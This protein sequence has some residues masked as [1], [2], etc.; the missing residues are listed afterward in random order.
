MW[1]YIIIIAF[2]I[3]ALFKERQ[4][5]GC[6]SILDAHEGK[7]CDNGNGK[8]IKGS[9][10]YPS[11]LSHVLCDKIDLAASY[12]DRFVKWRAIFLFSVIATLLLGFILHQKL[13]S[14]WEMVVS[15]SVLMLLALLAHGF[16]KFHL[17]DHVK[18]NIHTGTA[19][20][21]KKYFS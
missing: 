12:H 5:L 2:V 13:P 1:I 8:A 4:A 3:Y 16:Y 11:D 19:I 10:P 18:K 9:K 15:I 21:K 7:D 6:G 17:E 14:E 20:L